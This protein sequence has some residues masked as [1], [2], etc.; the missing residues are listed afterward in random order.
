MIDYLFI[1]CL[2]LVALGGIHDFESIL[3]LPIGFGIVMIIGGVLRIPKDIAYILKLRITRPKEY[4]VELMSILLY[5]VFAFILLSIP[6]LYHY[7]FYK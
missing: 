6:F 3:L 7:L 4:Y 5:W 2:S 1:D